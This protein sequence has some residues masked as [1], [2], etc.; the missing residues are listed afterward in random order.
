MAFMRRGE[1]RFF[2]RDETGRILRLTN[3]DA[4]LAVLIPDG[5]DGWRLELSHDE[6]KFGQARR[7]AM[8]SPLRGGA[9]LRALSRLLPFLNWG[10]GTRRTLV[11][12]IETIG[13]TRSTDKLLALASRDTTQLKTHFKTRRGEAAVGAL[14][15]RIRLA[16]EMALH[17]EAE[18]R[19]MEGE[20]AEL[21]A[22][23]REA[24]EIARIADS[25]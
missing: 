3:Q 6:S 23:W 4:R 16:M 9:A 19:A 20:L 8:R 5:D 17:D 24:D 1:P 14:P 10:G 7:S 25:L 22:R 13:A 2:V 21:Q 12:A 18:Q 15:G 11:D